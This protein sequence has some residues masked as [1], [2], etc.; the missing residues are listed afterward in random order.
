MAN[1]L[2]VERLDSRVAGEIAND[3]FMVN[4]QMNHFIFRV[5]YLDESRGLK[6]EAW[7]RPTKILYPANYS[8]QYKRIENEQEMWEKV[9]EAVK[10]HVFNIGIRLVDN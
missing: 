5:S 1:L 9:D 8:L 7:I 10:L 3:F 4:I 6:R 2:S